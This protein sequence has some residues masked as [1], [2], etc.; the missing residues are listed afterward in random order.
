MRCIISVSRDNIESVLSK[1]GISCC[2]RA[3]SYILEKVLST[4][5]ER[6]FLSA[7]PFDSLLLKNE[8]KNELNVG[9]VVNAT[10]DFAKNT[11]RKLGS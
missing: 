11:F 5:T 7:V 10:A 1:C 9:K 4:L 8:L 6:K 2:F 3:F